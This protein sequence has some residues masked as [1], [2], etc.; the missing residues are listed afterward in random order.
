[1]LTCPRWQRLKV[2]TLSLLEAESLIPASQH[3]QGLKQQVQ[4]PSA[5]CPS[6]P[7]EFI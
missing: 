4:P 3:L 6:G 5:L 1:M 7:Q 2:T